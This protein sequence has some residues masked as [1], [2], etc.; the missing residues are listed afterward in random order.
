MKP[1]E[2]SPSDKHTRQFLCEERVFW[3]ITHIQFITHSKPSIHTFPE[4]CCIFTDL[5]QTL[6]TASVDTHNKDLSK[7]F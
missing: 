4:L 5:H 1:D 6:R 3:L 7:E 2:K